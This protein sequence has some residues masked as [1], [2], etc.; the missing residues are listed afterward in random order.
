[1]NECDFKTTQLRDTWFYPPNAGVTSKGERRIKRC[2]ACNRR[3][4]L[5]ELHCVGGE[6]TG[7][8]IPTHKVRV[9]RKPGPRRTSRY[10][11]RGK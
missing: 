10:A 2:P 9:L 1:M 8:V 6:V 3:L 5:R 7:Y 4:S 11:G